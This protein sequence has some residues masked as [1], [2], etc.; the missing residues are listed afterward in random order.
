VIGGRFFARY[1]EEDEAPLRAREG[2]PDLEGSAS[3]GIEVD[4]GALTRRAGGCDDLSRR[5]R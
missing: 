5:E 2:V 3:A 4:V 1:W